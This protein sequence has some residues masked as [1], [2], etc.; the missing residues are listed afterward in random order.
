MDTIIL[1]SDVF[2]ITSSSFVI[3]PR[4]EQRMNECL[5]TTQ[6]TIGF[7]TNGIYIKQKV[8]RCTELVVF[9]IA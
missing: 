8:E 6:H 9:T 5:T 3:V 4:D 1:R 2:A 7:E